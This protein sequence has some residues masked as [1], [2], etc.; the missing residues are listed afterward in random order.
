MMAPLMACHPC[1]AL[2]RTVRVPCRPS[3]CSLTTHALSRPHRH[4]GDACYARCEYESQGRKR[5]N[6][7]QRRG[8]TG[9]PRLRALLRQG[10]CRLCASAP[11]L[12]KQCGSAHLLTDKCPPSLLHRCNYC[13]KR[14]YRAFGS[15]RIGRLFAGSAAPT[16]HWTATPGGCNTAARAGSATG[17]VPVAIQ[18][19]CRRRPR[20]RL[21]PQ[22]CPRLSARRHRPTQRSADT[23]GTRTRTRRRRSWRRR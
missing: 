10:W 21:R 4:C 2:V 9:A 12:S 8:S 5:A 17:T 1:C 16:T 15:R 18:T 7:T 14:T 11:T 13:P 6:A 22:H 23:R 20:P 19:T 3:P